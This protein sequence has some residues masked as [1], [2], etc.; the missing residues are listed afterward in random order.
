MRA[1]KEFLAAQIAVSRF[2]LRLL[3]MELGELRDDAP[4]TTGPGLQSVQL[5][6]LDLQSDDAESNQK[7]VSACAR[8]RLKSVVRMLHSRQDPSV[9]GEQK[10][11]ALQLA[12]RNGFVEVV[13]I[14][15]EATA[16]VDATRHDGSTAL[17]LAARNG[18]VPV[19][20]SLLKAAAKVGATERDGITVLMA[21][22]DGHEV[23]R[24]WHQGGKSDGQDGPTSLHVAAQNGHLE[25]VSSLVEAAAEV[26]AKTQYGATALH[27]AAHN[28]HIEVLQSLLQA[29]SDTDSTTH[30]GK[31]ALHIASQNGHLEV[32]ERLL[33]A[34]AQIH[35]TM[36]NG[37]TALHLAAMNGHLEVV[38]TLL[39]ASAQSDAVKQ[40]GATAFVLAGQNG[41]YEIAHLLERWQ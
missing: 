6:V 22:N 36:Q 39:E 19:V 32:V 2:R 35:A 1:L 12:A 4:L 26:N 21:S 27:L 13:R 41:Y 20:Q 34:G 10:A 11:S 30:A 25:V 38:R 16:E 40:D 3:D 15:L 31:T 23:V 7:F 5:L 8:N 17:F 24:S 14:L 29:N 9:S 28:A 33:V 18:N 37:A